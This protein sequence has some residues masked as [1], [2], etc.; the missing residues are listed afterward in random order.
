MWQW[1]I[2][3]GGLGAAVTFNLTLQA[4]E[5]L[6]P[7]EA[8]RQIDQRLS[9]ELFHAEDLNQLA[10]QVDDQIFLRRVF[11]DLI[12]QLPS[13]DD[14]IAFA[15]DTDPKKRESVIEKLLEDEAFGQ[16]WGHY[17]RDVIMYRRTEDR[18]LFAAQPLADYLA[19]QF[20]QNIPWD[21][22]ARSFITATGDVRENGATGLIMAQAGEP[23]DTVS[24]V[25]RIFTGIQ[26][27]C[28]QCHDHPTDRWQR[29]QFHELAAFFPRTGLRPKNMDGQRSF[30]VISVN[31]SPRRRGGPINVEF[32]FRRYDANKDGKLTK[33]EVKESR[34]VSNQ[35]DRFLSRVDQDKDQALSKEELQKIPP[36]NNRPGRGSPEHRMPDLENPSAPGKV[37]QPVFF[38]TG[39]SMETGTRDEERRE[40]LAHWITAK[41]NPWFGVAYVNRMWSELVGEGFYEPIDDLGPDRQAT[42]PET[43][44]YLSES[45]VKNNH[46]MKWLFR[47]IM[48]T[49]AYQRESRTRRNPDQT[50]FLANTAQRLRADQLYRVLWSAL[51]LPEQENRGPRRGGPRAVFQ[52]LFGYDPSNLRE[53][54][55]GSV[56]QA[57]AMMNSPI[58]N[59]AITGGR[60]TALGRMLNTM[61]KDEE[62]AVELYLKILARTPTEDELQ[63]CLQHVAQVDKRQEAFED[64]LWSLINSTE[65]LHRR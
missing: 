7:R 29:E 15:L 52:N 65:F 50:P 48:A 9:D 6:S 30:E 8:A 5:G 64:V 36:P 46:D 17:W 49:E 38:V 40:Q 59:Q 34:Q 1:V 20:N 41:N 14:V 33:D 32:L 58:V 35:F 21:E 16:N 26:I 56:P 22:T 12:G 10:P 61:E 54:I 2:S 19:L 51:E 4:A 39:Q 60:R 55:K 27:Q 28:A 63:V 62:I 42:A 43:L 3:L 23:E 13:P 57:L 11:L 18:A 25:A 53:E 47:T 44:A 24:E 31:Q 45:F 37:M